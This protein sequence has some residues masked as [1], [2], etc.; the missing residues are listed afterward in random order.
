M[1]LIILL[2]IIGIPPLMFWGHHYNRVRL[3]FNLGATI[4]VLIFGWILTD[5]IYKI[6]INQ[7]VFMTSIHGVFLNPSFLISGAYFGWYLLNRLLIL[8]YKEFEQ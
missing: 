1:N 4:S 7:E 3:L 5:G 8:I 6:L 2:A